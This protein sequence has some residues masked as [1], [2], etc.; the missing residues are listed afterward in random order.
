MLPS[1]GKIQFSEHSVLYEMLIP[2][3]EHSRY[4]R[5]LSYGLPCMEM[6]GAMTIF[7][8]NL[9]EGV[10]FSALQICGVF[11]YILRIFVN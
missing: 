4:D 9:V 5:A 1:Q 2:V 7:A 11:L 10:F 8:A 6:Q 3:V